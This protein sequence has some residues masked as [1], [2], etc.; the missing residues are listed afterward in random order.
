VLS[1][2]AERRSILYEADVSC[3]IDLMVLNEQRRNFF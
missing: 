2:R 3:L 1:F